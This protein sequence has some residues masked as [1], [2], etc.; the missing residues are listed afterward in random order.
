MV[1]Q[2]VK[3]LGIRLIYDCEISQDGLGRGKFHL[4]YSNDQS[5]FISGLRL[6]AFA[7]KAWLKF[8]G[9][10]PWFQLRGEGIEIYW[11]SKYL[12]FRLLISADKYKGC[13]K[14]CNSISEGRIRRLARPAGRGFLFVVLCSVLLLFKDFQPP[15][16]L[17]STLGGSP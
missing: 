16:L 14:L 6:Q 1:Y 8:W 4:T 9:F 12:T 5:V 15:T 17:S 11:S 3:F 7:W 2:S 13:L 10:C